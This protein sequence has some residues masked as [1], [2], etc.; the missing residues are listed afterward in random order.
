[1][2]LQIKMLAPFLWPTV[3]AGFG[4]RVDFVSAHWGSVHTI[5]Y[6]RV[7]GQ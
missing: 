7:H 2:K 4:V 3:A 6:V 5:R 1:M